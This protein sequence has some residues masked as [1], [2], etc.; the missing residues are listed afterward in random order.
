MT[1][2]SQYPSWTPQTLVLGPGG[3]K[4]FYI[5]GAL[6][7]LERHGWLNDLQTCVGVSI[8]SVIGLLL[9][10]GYQVTEIIEH[11]LSISLFHDFMSISLAQVHENSGLI[12]NEQV[13]SR[14]TERLQ[15]KFGFVPTLKQLY[16]FTAINFVAVTCNI[17]KGRTEYLSKDTEPDLSAVEA[18]ML[19]MNI[20]FIFYKLRYKGCTYV[21]GALGHPYPV[22]V[23]DDGITPVLGITI[24][25]NTESSS[26]DSL[27][28]YIYGIIH[29]VTNSLRHVATRKLSANCRSLVLI[30]QHT[31][32]I[33]LDIDDK[34]RTDMIIS[35]YEAA[36]KFANTNERS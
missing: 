8:G 28:S 9:T 15:A 11:S 4:G 22:D 27:G 32:T 19:S 26:G 17:D 21:D 16:E 31:A 14:L 2:R 10:A 29:T 34:T 24:D 35:G 6:L 7:Y 13:K 5:M 3:V 1:E 18:V 23:Y 20:P 25:H 33:G 30:A 12:S 36:R